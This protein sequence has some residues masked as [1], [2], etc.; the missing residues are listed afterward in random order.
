MKLTMN[1]VTSILSAK[2]L[3]F[4][5]PLLFQ[6]FKTLGLFHPQAAVFLAPAAI[7][8]LGDSQPPAGFAYRGPLAE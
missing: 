3:L 1:C 7:G 2:S 4:S 8:L 5:P 6:I